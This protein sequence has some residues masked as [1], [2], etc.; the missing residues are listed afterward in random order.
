MSNYDADIFDVTIIGSGPNG[1]SAAIRLAQAG[2][3]VLVLEGH[4]TIGGGARSEELTIFG[5]THDICSAIHPLGLAS[6][7]LRTLPL[8]EYGL[9]WVHPKV[10]FA[11]AL[12][13]DA[14]ILIHQ[15]L[16]TTAETLGNDGRAWKKLFAPFV[17]NFPSRPN[18]RS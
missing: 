17:E 9:E 18:T 2:L 12:D 10:P 5:Y 1:L 6:P 14:P 4:E 3:S 11:H 8:Y 15:D 16:N 13:P 7:F